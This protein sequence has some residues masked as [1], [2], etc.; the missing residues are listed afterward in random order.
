MILDYCK[1][2]NARYV[3]EVQFTL[4]NRFR[5]DLAR[6]RTFQGAINLTDDSFVNFTV[7]PNDCVA[8]QQMWVKI[9]NL[10]NVCLFKIIRMIFRPIV[11]G[12]R[13]YKFHK[14]DWVEKKHLNNNIS[15]EILWR[16]LIQAIQ[17]WK[18]GSVEALKILLPT[19]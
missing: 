14:Q 4:P 19:I 11:S 17:V 7:V 5:L 10:K 12:L 15:L 18:F 1:R 8:L 3:T 16:R 6:L 13:L 9:I 2:I